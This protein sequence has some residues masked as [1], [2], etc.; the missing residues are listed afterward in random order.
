MAVWTASGPNPSFGARGRHDALTLEATVPEEGIAV[1]TDGARSLALEASRLLSRLH[2]ITTE[3]ASGFDAHSLAESAMDDLELAV[4][5]DRAALY[6]GYADTRPVV[7]AVRGSDRSPWPDPHT[8]DS[9]LNAGWTLDRPVMATAVIGGRKRVFLTHPMQNGAGR[10]VGM[11]V[12]DRPADRPFQPDEVDAFAEVATDYAPFVDSAMLFSW[13]RTRSGAEERAR[14]ANQIHN[15]IAQEVV[16]LGFQIDSLRLGVPGQDPAVREMLDGLRDVVTR[17]VADL[18]ARISDLKLDT[19]PNT[20]VGA[21]ILDR[22]Q[23]VGAYTGLAIRVQLHESGTRLPLNIEALVYRLALDLIS[24]ATSALKATAIDLELET[25]QSGV[26]LTV[27]HDGASSTLRADMFEQHPLTERGAALRFDPPAEGRGPL[28]T[29]AWEAQNQPDDDARPKDPQPA[30]RPGRS[31]GS[32]LEMTI[33]ES[34][35]VH[36]DLA[37]RPTADAGRSTRATA[38]KAVQP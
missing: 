8:R 28:L 6:S 10:R 37:P 34:P 15:G 31:G 26:R 20:S 38:G 13:L 7:L 4:D 14:A 17:M 25:S 29:L 35:D 2:A 19:R 12:A 24:D 1:H 18:R 33:I 11:F 23:V 30:S 36:V 22:L 21:L 27:G 16:A 32:T 3:L 5:I 9:I